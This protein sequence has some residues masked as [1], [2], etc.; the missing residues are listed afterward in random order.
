MHTSQEQP[1]V[2]IP[3]DVPEPRTVTFM[4]NRSC[5]LVTDKCFLIVLR[6]IPTLSIESKDLM[7]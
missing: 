7:P 6:V 3:E 4:T 1:I 5:Y 2:G